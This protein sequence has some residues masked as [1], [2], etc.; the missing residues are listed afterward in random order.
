MYRIWFERKLPQEHAHLID[1]VA[2]PLGFAVA[3]S[4][5]PLAE[6]AQADAVIA[7]A[8]VSYDAAL[9]DSAP[10]LKVIARTG[11]GYDNIS[12]ADATARG[13][14]VCYTPD[15][16]TISTAEHTIALMLAAAKQLKRY[17]R[18]MVEQPTAD[19]ISDYYGLELYG[20]RLGLVGLGRIGSRV[21]HVARALGM[22]VAAYDPFVPP[23]RAAE[24]GVELAPSLEALLGESDVV[25][26]HVPAS[27]ETRHLMNAERLAQMKPGAYLINAARGALVDEA[28][29]LEAL[30]SGHLGG[31]GLDVFEAEPPPGDHPL[32]SRGD[33][34]ATPHLAGPSPAGRQRMWEGAIGQALQVL[35]NERPAHLLNPDVWSAR[36]N[37]KG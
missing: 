34:I 21:A 20:R 37:G 29:L 16:P 22:S 6:I 26:L 4:A 33:V 30:D 14:C 1:G 36:R 27:A 24:M 8:K 35:H 11:V 7:S 28:A 10:A 13:I 32:L 17:N 15:A 12:V 23:G 18:A 5:D 25:S 2:R 31:A 9:M 19:H 3:P